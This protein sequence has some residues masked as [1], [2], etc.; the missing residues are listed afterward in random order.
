VWVYVQ[1]NGKRDVE[2]R[3]AGLIEKAGYKVKVLKQSVPLKDR[4][5]WIDKN[6]QDVDVVISHPRLVETGLDLF[7]KQYLG[8]NFATLVFYETGYVL[9]TMRQASRRAWRLMQPKECKVYYLYYEKTMQQRA[10][11]LM[12]KKLLAAE[13]LE[14]K[15]SSE[16]LV[17]LAGDDGMEM[18][19]AKSLADNMAKDENVAEAW[20]DLTKTHPKK[21]S[22]KME[23][24]IE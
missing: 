11:E 15:F 7:S 18:A 5:E 12:G 3:V 4:E 21:R 10:M 8:H 19:L 6:C 14:G 23:M 9:P 13:A 16:G 1:L 2:S 22:R 24:V 20:G 17:A